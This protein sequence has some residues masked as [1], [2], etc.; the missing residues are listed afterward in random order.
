MTSV[1]HLMDPVYAARKATEADD[2]WGGIDTSE[3]A[4]MC[5]SDPFWPDDCTPD[6]VRDAAIASLRDGSGAHYSSP[7]GEPEL[8]AEI[9]K[10]VARLNGIQVDPSRNITVGGG[11]VPLFIFAM[12]PFLEPGRAN[13]I[14]TPAPSWVT[15]Y[16]IGPLSGGVTVPV[17]T[18]AEDGYDLRIDEFEKRLTPRTKMIL[19]ANPNNPTTTV[20]SRSAL[21]GLAEFA[22]SNDLIVVTDQV[23]EDVVF[24][25]HE[26][27]QI[28]AMDGMADRTI[29]ISSLSKGMALCGHRLGYVVASEEISD[30]LH[31]CAAHFLG[32][33][34]T[35]AQAAAV[36]A[37]RAPEF[38]EE[39][40][41]EYMARAEVICSMLDAV[42]NLKFQR[43]QSA[44]FLW[45]DVAAFGGARQT[46]DYLLREAK[47]LTNEGDAWGSDTHLRLVY[48]NYADRQ[49]CFDAISRIVDALK[50]HPL[51]E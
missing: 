15:N 36:A 17:P 18:Y 51:N 12:R 43:P 31:S 32:A 39:Y 10:R 28:A 45:L 42:P 46:A 16:E 4:L 9:A 13:E 11:S 27:T 3:V 1:R 40:R 30:V 41:R 5:I 38:L 34:N 49:R 14:L 37:L 35:V 23:F 50:R 21:E 22:R 19:I 24:D 6:Y 29:L 33:P 26:M 2:H 48:S 25:G 7:I 44:Y 8:R 20:Y 47:V